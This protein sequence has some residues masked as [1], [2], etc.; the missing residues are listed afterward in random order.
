L[1]RARQR[2]PW[3]SWTTPV[4][5]GLAGSG[6]RPPVVPVDPSSITATAEG[7]PPDD[8][9]GDAPDAVGVCDRVDLDDRTPGDGEPEHRG[10]PSAHG[11]DRPVHQRG[12]QMGARERAHDRLPGDGGCAVDDPAYARTSGAEVGAQLGSRGGTGQLN[13]SA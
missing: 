11:D 7:P 8:A 6:P 10:G 5:G 4:R 13:A 3:R 2:W 1:P 12:V 9:R